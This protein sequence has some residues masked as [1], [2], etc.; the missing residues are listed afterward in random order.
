MSMSATSPPLSAS[1]YNNANNPLAN[2]SMNPS[3]PPSKK[4]VLR[5]A[6]VRERCKSIQGC[7]ELKN[8]DPF[9][10]TISFLILPIPPTEGEE[11]KSQENPKLPLRISV[12]CDTGTVATAKVI[13]G[14]VR[15]SFRR[16]V[17]SLDVMERLIRHPEGPVEINSQLIGVTDTDDDNENANGSLNFKKGVEL[18]DVGLCILEG[19]REKLAKHIRHID[20]EAEKEASELREQQAKQQREKQQREQEAVKQ[21]QQPSNRLPQNSISSKQTK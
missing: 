10:T 12:F 17:T 14:Q 2:N 7:K 8:K 4:N 9:S 6:A 19:E 20:D 15:H 11:S 5:P 18:A 21:K 1:F 3:K 13:D 16:N